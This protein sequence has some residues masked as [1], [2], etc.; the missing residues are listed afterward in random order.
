M[1]NSAAS[2]PNFTDSGTA[3]APMRY[4]A[5]CATA[6]SADCAHI[7]ATRS[8]SPTPRSRRNVMSRRAR[9]PSSPNVVISGGSS[10]RSTTIAGASWGCASMHAAPMLNRSGI[11][12]W[13]P[14]GRSGG[15]HGRRFVISFTSSGMP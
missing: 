15:L 6:V 12:Q 11:S 7:T 13:K 3:M 4:A 8:P 10:P 9:S 1:R 5:M 2:G 14:S